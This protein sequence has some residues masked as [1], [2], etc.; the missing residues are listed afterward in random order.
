[1][2]RRYMV[3]QRLGQITTR[4]GLELE[5]FTTGLPSYYVFCPMRR[6]G[7]GTFASGTIQVSHH[8]RDLVRGWK[9]LLH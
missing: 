8:A 5:V 7:S 9:R 4:T 2:D 1:M 6:L 3:K